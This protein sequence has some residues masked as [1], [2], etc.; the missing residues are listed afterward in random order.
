MPIIIGIHCI[1]PLTEGSATMFE[2]AKK[3]QKVTDSIISQ[4]RDA[5]LSGQLKPGDRLASEKELIDQF[6]V[7]KATLR[8]ALRA[9]E[10]MGLVQTRKGAAGGV[11]ITEVN[12]QTTIHSMMNF[13]HFRSVSISE[14]T[15]LR[16]MMEPIIVRIAATK[17]TDK[18]LD[19]LATYI[20]ENYTDAE[21]RKK[22]DISFHRYL[23]RMTKNSML[24]LIIDFIESLLNEIK[25]LLE[26]EADFYAM[27][28]N[29]H[30]RILDFL[31]QGDAINASRAMAEDVIM[32]GKYLSDKLGEKSFDPSDFGL[33][34]DSTI[35][36]SLPNSNGNEMDGSH[37]IDPAVLQLREL[38]NAKIL[39]SMDNTTLYMIVP[40]KPEN[41]KS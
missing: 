38:V 4:I 23:S 3:H 25:Q 36:A 20:S 8:E 31:I 29:N 37:D 32:V 24:I 6:G 9:L 28:N 35:G 39:K 13:L 1:Q 11:Y 30:R 26:L 40:R 33:R 27:V 21:S 18:E 12:L 19:Q 10:A 15:M 5:V 16:Y 34:D 2:M 41:E 7:S 14:V 22:K 17:I